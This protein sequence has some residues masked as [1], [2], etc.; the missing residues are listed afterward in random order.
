MFPSFLKM[1]T[2]TISQ[3]DSRIIQFE[4][5]L[6]LVNKCRKRKNEKD[7]TPKTMHF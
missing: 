3:P 4:N 1:N 6:G 2:F 5:R 7:Q